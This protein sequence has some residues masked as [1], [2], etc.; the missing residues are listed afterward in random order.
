MKTHNLYNL[1]LIDP[2]SQQNTNKLFI[3]SGYASA[4]FARRH[5]IESRAR[6]RNLEINL[7][8]GMPGR[9][10]DDLAF[11][12]LHNEFK[13]N[14][15]GYYFKNTPPVH[16]K[17]YSWFENDIPKTGFAG[18][19]NYSQPGFFS[20]Y[21]VNQISSED[22]SKIKELFE[23]LLK[24]SIFIPLSTDVVPTGTTVPVFGGSVKPG[25]ILWEIPNKRVRISF[26]DTHG[27]LPKISGLNW[28][29]RFEKRIN[30]V[31]KKV[32]YVNRERN[33]AY[34]SLKGSSRDSG[35]L[36]EKAYTFT[37]VTDDGHTFDCVVAQDG[38]KAIE[39]NKNNSLLG[40]YFRERLKLPLG[41]LVTVEHLQQYGR[42]DYTIEKMDE[43]T[44]LMDFSIK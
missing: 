21:Q 42:T 12:E 36:P 29:Q 1:V 15:K 40:V 6:E 24:D 3:I 11:K 13:D 32:T 38:R 14:F 37:L 7:I 8:I 26:L 23:I 18:S 28:G 43:E 35:F 5:L 16:C 4:T 44:F 25:T 10:N 22:P 17:A 2:M 30:P 9:R 34:L 27:I 20:E 19:A 31:T 39:T 33:Q 41:E